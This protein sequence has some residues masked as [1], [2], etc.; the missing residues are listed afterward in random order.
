MR[1][2]AG[3]VVIMLYKKDVAKAPVSLQLREG[4]NAGAE[5]V[6]HTM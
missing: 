4:Q 5:T 3:K 1:R 6:T 2:I